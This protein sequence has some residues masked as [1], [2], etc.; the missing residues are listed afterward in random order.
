MFR[1]FKPKR[2]QQ[3]EPF[4]SFMN[5]RL[6]LS[7]EAVLTEYIKKYNLA[8]RF[9]LDEPEKITAARTKLHILEETVFADPKNCDDPDFQV[10]LTALRVAVTGYDRIRQRQREAELR[11]V[12]PG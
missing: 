6:H 11:E 8:V 12:D 1:F 9:H 2:G 5:E 4:E 10:Y 3:R 7:I